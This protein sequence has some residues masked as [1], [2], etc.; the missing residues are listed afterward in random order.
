[1]DRKD[2][3]RMQQISNMMRKRQRWVVRLE[4]D[5]SDIKLNKLVNPDN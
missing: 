5:I 4:Y 3:R 1:M 2:I